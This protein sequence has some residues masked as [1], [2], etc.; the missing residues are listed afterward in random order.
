MFFKAARIGSAASLSFINGLLVVDD[1]DSKLYFVQCV[2][3]LGNTAF[4]NLHTAI[5]IST[6]G[7]DWV[8][9]ESY[10]LS[11]RVAAIDHSNNFKGFV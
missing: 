7:V 9:G 2:Q 10:G 1:T 8:Y 11:R 4:S 6:F 5:D 3:I